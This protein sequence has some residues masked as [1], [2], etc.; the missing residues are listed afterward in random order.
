MAALGGLADCFRDSPALPIS[1]ASFLSLQAG[2]GHL[3]AQYLARVGHEEFSRPLGEAWLT[4][5]HWVLCLKGSQQR[6]KLG[7]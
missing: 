6:T 4:P 3:H 2:A 1:D 5:S 7:L